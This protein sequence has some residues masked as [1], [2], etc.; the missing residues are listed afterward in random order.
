MLRCQSLWRDGCWWK[1]TQP[2]VNPIDSAVRAGYLQSMIPLTFPATIAGDFAGVIKEVSRGVLDLGVGDEVFGFAPVIAGG[3]GTA[4]DYTATNVSMVARKPSRTNYAEAAGLPLAGVSAVQALDQMKLESR[5]RVLI[6]GGAGG[7]G[8]FA[9]QYA[10]YLGCHVATTVRG[11]QK[12]FVRK[13]DADKIVDF[14]AEEFD[15]ALK[16]Y[17]AVLDTVGGE[18]H[19]RSF[20]TLK[21][22]GIVASMVQNSPDQ[23]LILKFGAR[24]VYVSTQVNTASLIHIAELVDKGALKTQIAR[25]YPLEQTRDAFTYFEQDHPKGKICLKIR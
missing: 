1:F 12:E 4:A 16:E 6:H 9:I 13:L 7:I 23:E 25:E 10:K 8:S 3:S 5:Q 24:A 15:S 2:S 11:S 14:E 18:V 17:D 20:S 21:K 19:K 22:G